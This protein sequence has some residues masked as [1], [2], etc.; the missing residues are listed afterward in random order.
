MQKII[1]SK[2]TPS[3]VILIKHA[4]NHFFLLKKLKTTEYALCRRD[5][6]KYP[7]GKLGTA[8]EI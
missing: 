4:K 6:Q 3:Q 2:S 8:L 1:F 7:S 5:H